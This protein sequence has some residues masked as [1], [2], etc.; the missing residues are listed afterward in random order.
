LDTPQ[1]GFDVNTST[2]FRPTRYWD[3]HTFERAG[4]LA[5]EP[6]ESVVI[7]AVELGSTLSDVI[8]VRA[9]P[10]PAGIRYSVVDEYDSEFTIVPETS[11]EPLTMGELIGL[12]DSARVRGEEGLAPGLVEPF[13][14]LN[15]ESDVPPA[16]LRNFIR[17][18]S[19]FYPELESYYRGR[20]EAWIDAAERRSPD[21]GG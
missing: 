16:E 20:V 21:R 13:L 7:A 4:P 19:E 14:E 6:P 18:V 2:G 3:E 17:V 8:L 10:D 12:I 11:P 9:E 1:G 5:D 15:L